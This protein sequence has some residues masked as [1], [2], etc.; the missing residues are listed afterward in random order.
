MGLGA[1]AAE[2]GECMVAGEGGLTDEEGLRVVGE[3]D[4]VGARSNVSWVSKRK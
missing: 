3:R 1:A 4:G 2:V